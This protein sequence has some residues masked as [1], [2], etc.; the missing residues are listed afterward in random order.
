MDYNELTVQELQELADE[1]D[2]EYNSR[3][4]KADL[5]SALEDSEP[6]D[7]ATYIAEDGQ[8]YQRPDPVVPQDDAVA[9]DAPVYENLPR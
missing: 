3:D 5:I 7:D 2:V 1:R 6:G 8:R 9:Q 4:R